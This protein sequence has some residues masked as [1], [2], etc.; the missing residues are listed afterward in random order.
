MNDLHKFRF[1]SFE[2]SLKVGAYGEY[3]TRE[4]N[5]RNFIYNWNASSNTMPEN[6]RYMDI[7][8]L[9]SNGGNFGTDRLYLLEQMNMRNDYQCFRL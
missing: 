1:G 5:T 4:Y 6:F 8:A 7:P 2:P 9:L 3:R